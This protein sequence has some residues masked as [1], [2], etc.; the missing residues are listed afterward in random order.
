[1]F[2]LHL[3]STADCASIN[4]SNP[5]GFTG[6]M[7]LILFITCIYYQQIMCHNVAIIITC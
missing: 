6:L 4:H 7:T 5:P 1:M 2:R 3:Q